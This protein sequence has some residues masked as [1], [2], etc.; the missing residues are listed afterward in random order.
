MLA[1]HIRHPTNPP[2]PAPHLTHTQ[3]NLV[4]RVTAHA[5]A[6]PNIDREYYQCWLG[7]KSHFDPGWASK[8]TGGGSATNDPGAGGA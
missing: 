5:L 6:A 2:C 7:L 8:A 1:V 4:P 3:T